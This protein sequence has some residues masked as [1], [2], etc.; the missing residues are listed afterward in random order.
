MKP[1]PTI[2]A[3]HFP[4]RHD[5]RDLGVAVSAVV[6][7]GVFTIAAGN[8]LLANGDPVVTAAPAPHVDA[9][10]GRLW[11]RVQLSGWP[12]ATTES[13]AAQAGLV[14]RG[15]WISLDGL[16]WEHVDG[17]VVVVAHP[18]SATSPR[19]TTCT[20]SAGTDESSRA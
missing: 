1:T 3:L 6:A 20:A 12:D 8:T 16:T 5:L 17:R 13:A 7:A 9:E 2:R 10:C 19:D 4:I 15:S 11:D 14:S 18:R